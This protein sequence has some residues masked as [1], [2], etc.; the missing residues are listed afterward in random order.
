MK[1]IFFRGAI[2]T[3]L[4]LCQLHAFAQKMPAE[5]IQALDQL[6]SLTSQG[7]AIQDEDVR[8]WPVY[9]IAGSWHAS[10]SGILKNDP[11]WN[12][13]SDCKVIRGAEVG[14]IA[15]LRIPL[16]CISDFPFDAVFNYVELAHRVSPHLDRARYD[17]RTDS[18]HAGTGLPQGFH[19]E[20]VII[21]VT[22]WGFD[23]THPM[24]YDTLMQESR[25]I[26]AWDQFKQSGP[27]PDLFPYGTEYDTPS[28][29]LTA[30]GDTANIYSYHT[31]GQHVA[32]I[33]GGGGAGIEY[34]GMA[35]AAEFL[36]VTFLI[37]DAAV[38]DAFQWMKQKADSLDKRLVI[39]MSWGLHYM[40]TLDGNSL[41]SQVISE[42]SEQGVIFVTSAGNNGDV[43]FHIK[44]EFAADTMRTRVQFGTLSVPNMWGQSITM[45]GEP[46]QSFHS[47][48]RILSG[49]NVEL[50]ASPFYHT[51]TQQA[52]LDSFLVVNDDT[53]FFNL[54]NDAAHPLNGR[55]HMRLRIKSFS[56]TYKVILASAAE[57]GVVHYWNVV[58]LTTGV[59][60]W[61]QALM[62]PGLPG[63]LAGNAQYSISEP[64]CAH[65][66][67][68]VAAH[69]PEYLSQGG[70][71][72]GGQQAS[73]TSIGPLITEEMKPDISAPGVNITSSISSFTD[74]SY[75]ETASVTFNGTEYPF[76][77]FSGT[78]MASPAA[79]GVVA[80]VLDANPMLTA[81]QVKAI[82]IE[83][84]RL[85]NFTGA[86]GEDGHVRWG[87]GKVNAYAA[88]LLALETVGVEETELSFRMS[89]FPNPALERIQFEWP[90]EDEVSEVIAFGADGKRLSLPFVS[91]SADVSALPAGIYLIAV[92]SKTHLHTGRIVV[93]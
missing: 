88:V 71:L 56:G 34:R 48:L 55:P 59:G 66:A 39:N 93:Q 54:I 13:F 51:A 3:A 50:A 79:A 92:K 77:R 43:N 47:S 32:G 22:D 33:A 14:R 58:E 85:D 72:L 82:L 23:Y 9:R 4:I 81:A 83:T 91:R 1:T 29:L 69:S 24:L 8:Q 46:G 49:N 52:W 80:L 37:D 86:I 36:L 45:W 25:I 61:G 78:S 38:I 7:E 15:T 30:Q 73:F 21:G 10:F 62:N 89:F 70:N 19:G 6:H 28:E 16:S 12:A 2:V 11:D 65:D 26:A 53:I 41:L 68:A 44:K 42:L 64:A 87:H 74:A 60:N 31:H 18:V 63:G 76:A 75:F 17:T 20:D 84:A 5:T 57:S 90:E 35:P 40:G 27:S 67:I